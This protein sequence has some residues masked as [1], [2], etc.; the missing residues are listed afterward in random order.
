[1]AINPNEL[2]ALTEMSTHAVKVVA[3]SIEQLIDEHVRLS[4]RLKEELV[5]AKSLVPGIADHPTED[6]LLA[7]SVEL[8]DRY[9][10]A[11]WR[12]ANLRIVAKQTR[13][14]A[15]ALHVSYNLSE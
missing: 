2:K 6:G 1:M 15:L 10:A 9:T 5:L 3:D 14:Q 12:I 13:N 11:G 7:V 8:C 4:G